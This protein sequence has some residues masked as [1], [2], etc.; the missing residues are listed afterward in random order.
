MGFNMDESI[1]IV[2]DSGFIKA[3]LDETR[4]KM[5]L[6]MA[7]EPKTL[8][9]LAE[10]LGKTPATIHYHIKRLSKA[11]IV[12]LVKTRVV[13]N[14]LVEK[15][16]QTTLSSSCIVGIELS[17]R[18]GPVPP[19]KYKEIKAYLALDKESIGT[20]MNKLGISF[21]PEHEGEILKD[22]ND[23]ISV[24]PLHSIEV[25]RSL[26][27]Q[28]N[29]EMPLRSLQ[30]LE[31]IIGALPA[32]VFLEVLKKPEYLSLLRRMIRSVRKV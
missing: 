29:F 1:K 7:R 5:V 18:K 31:A 12:K 11:G 3:L 17:P 19:K 13:N 32:L 9:E 27:P 2:E 20:I 14:N 4:R 10:N 30:R 28:Q 22:V 26:Y 25:F 16:Y 8:T 21:P 6:E 15:Y 24:I 23:F